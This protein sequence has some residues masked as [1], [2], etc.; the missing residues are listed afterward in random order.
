MI[1]RLGENCCC[2]NILK[3]K[4]MTQVIIGLLNRQ[5]IE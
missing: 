5:K 1:V 3:G 2:S 4:E